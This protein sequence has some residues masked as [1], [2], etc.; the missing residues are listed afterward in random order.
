[1][2]YINIASGGMLLNL[3]IRTMYLV[4][5]VQVIAS[6]KRRIFAGGSSFRF[7]DIQFSNIGGWCYI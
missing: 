7:C 3:V 4:I 6:P 1:M 2:E 5:L